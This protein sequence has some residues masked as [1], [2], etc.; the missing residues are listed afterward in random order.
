LETNYDLYRMATD[1]YLGQ[2]VLGREIPKEIISAQIY[3]R[4]RGVLG[5]E[6]SKEII[7]A[8]IYRR[9]RGVLGREVSKEIRLTS[10]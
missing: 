4:G 9:G 3:R 2:G 1:E 6:V 7:S 10:V 5:R 8:Q